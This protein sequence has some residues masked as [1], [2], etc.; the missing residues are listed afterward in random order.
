[1]KTKVVQL[2]LILVGCEATGFSSGLVS[3]GHMAY[4]AG[5]TIGTVLIVAGF[6]LPLILRRK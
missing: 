6:V 2:V 4:V 5:I 1:M 3:E